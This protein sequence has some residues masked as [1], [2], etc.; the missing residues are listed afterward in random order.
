MSGPRRWGII[1][2]APTEGPQCGYMGYV[3]FHENAEAKKPKPMHWHY[4]ADGRFVETAWG[5]ESACTHV[6][7]APARAGADGG[8]A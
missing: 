6:D 4:S 2:I 1:C 3:A 8:D 7:K 5:S